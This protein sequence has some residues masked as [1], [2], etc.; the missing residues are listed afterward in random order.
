MKYVRV[1]MKSHPYAEAEQ[2]VSYPREQKYH[3][4][5]RAMNTSCRDD[6]VPVVYLNIPKT[7]TKVILGQKKAR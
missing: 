1:C 6:T 2:T 7:I 5:G 4:I 3:P